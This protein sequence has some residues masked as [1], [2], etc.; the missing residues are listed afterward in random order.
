MK[1]IVLAFLTI[2][3]L[4]AQA[5]FFYSEYLACKGEIT[6]DTSAVHPSY[7]N[8]AIL[9]RSFWSVRK[10]DCSLAPSSEA[11][12]G[13]PDDLDFDLVD[14]E[15]VVRE[16]GSSAWYGR[17]MRWEDNSVVIP[18]LDYMGYGDDPLKLTVVDNNGDFLVLEGY[19]SHNGSVADTGKGYG[20]NL[21]CVAK[22]STGADLQ[23]LNS[24][25]GC[26]NYPAK[27]YLD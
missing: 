21:K 10:K 18:S 13:Y 5:D 12:F 23:V 14:K 8:V 17:P 25:A 1:S 24:T 6:G 4:S 9:V 11:A 20:Y 7:N 2:F 22:I 16:A 26:S 15:S 27:H 19:W 3:G